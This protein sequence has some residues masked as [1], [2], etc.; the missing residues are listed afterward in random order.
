MP[1][2][3]EADV[4]TEL[5]DAKKAIEECKADG[6]LGHEVYWMGY[7]DALK[8]VHDELWDSDEVR[9]EI[10]RVHKTIELCREV[11]D[12]VGSVRWSGYARALEVMLNEGEVDERRRDAK[13]AR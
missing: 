11:G 7:E 4:R 3:S 10:N 12:V 9:S 8:D 13:E 2:W 5:E 6:D 1:M